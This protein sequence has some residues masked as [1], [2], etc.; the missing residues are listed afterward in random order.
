MTRKVLAGVVACVA[1]VVL[2]LPGA[3][4]ADKVEKRAWNTS[5]D[6]RY[7]GDVVQHGSLPVSRSTKDLGMRTLERRSASRTFAVTPPPSV[8]TEAIWLGLDDAA[9][10]YDLKLFTLRAIG[11]H[12]EVW[13]SQELDFP[14]GDC[15]NGPRTQITDTQVSYLLGQFDT[16]IY[17]KESA[18]FSV[19]PDRDGSGELLSDELVSDGLPEYAALVDPRGAGDRTAILV[20]NVRDENYYDRDNSTGSSYIAGFFS[21]QLN[22]IFDRNVMT[23][24]AFDWLHRTGAN[25]PDQ[26][27]PGNFCTSAPARPFLYEGVFAHENQHLLESYEDPDEATWVNEGLSDWAMTL[28]GYVNPKLPITDKGF[29]S[30]I[31]CLLGY[32]GVATPANPNPDTEPS[33]PENSLT[34]WGDQGDDEI[35]CDYGAASS[36]MEFLAG[37]YGPPVH[38]GAPPR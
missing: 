13:V 21:G 30:H 36:M 1:L 26:P 37:R 31:Q 20:D 22:E 34:R 3:G 17:P 29:A 5:Q 33:G 32:L 12:A 10:Q 16:T 15:R 9:Q 14:D 4:L 27:V 19:A 18:T 28:T 38:V 35:L 8:G 6:I 11:Q 7:P 24:D 25:P 2:A 23:I